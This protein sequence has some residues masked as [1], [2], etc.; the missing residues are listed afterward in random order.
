MIQ[1]IQTVFLLLAAIAL[2]A[3]MAFPIWNKTNIQSQEKIE[4]NAFKLE[5]YVV[6]NAEKGEKELLFSKSTIYLA[7]VAVLAALV[8][9]YSIIQFKNR[10]TQIKLGALNS[11]LIAIYLIGSV[12]ISIYQAENM[13][14]PEVRGSYAFG[15]FLPMMAIV[16]NMLANRFIRK[17]E[18]LVR[19]VD[20]IR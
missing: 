14:D 12:Y 20:R 6:K 5:H 10:L 18:Q 4:L 3:S 17:D 2:L 11:L 1:R 7:I 8:S 19:S 13:L 15:L 9:F 16:F